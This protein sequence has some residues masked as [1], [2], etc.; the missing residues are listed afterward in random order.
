MENIL[1]VTIDSLRADHVGY[2]GYDRDTTPFIDSLAE[3]GSTFT[4]AYAHVGG[5]RFSF[6][7]ILSGVTP[8]MYGGYERISEDQ[9]LVSE[10]FQEAGYRTGGFHS[11]L[12]VSAEFG[13]DRGFEEFYDSKE[14]P[15]LTSQVRRFVRTNMQDSALYPILQKGYDFVE[16]S[17]GVNI[18]SYH[19]PADELTDM[20]LDFVGDTDPDRP[21]FLWVHYMDVHHPFIPPAEHQRAF[22]DSVV[23]DRE[24]IKLRRKALEGPDELTEDE[25]GTLVDLYDAEIR[26]ND[27]EV[28]RL[29]E[30]TREE[31]NDVT[32][33]LTADHGE[34]FLEHGY[35]SG[36][37]PYDVKLHVP[38]LVDGW[39]D[40]G[41]YDELVGLVDL[42]PTL[43]DV[44]GLDVPDS[45]QGT[46]LCRLVFDGEWNR[47][48]IMGG[49]EIP[50]PT[51]VYR[52]LR[53]KYIQRPG[54][55]SD[56]LYDLEADPDESENVIDQHPERVEQ[57][58]TKLAD[59]K[60]LIERTETDVEAVEIDENVKERLRRLGYQE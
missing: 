57:F 42:P 27:A 18:G 1:L 52:D 39:D 11:N 50:E 51:Y 32:V 59:H 14:D 3:T 49:W 7:S 43:L 34:H 13:Y 24:A 30:T 4:N 41:S 33:A 10:V 20:A 58:E 47:T 25:L 15:S 5:T 37:Q 8:L 38:L 16:S 44:A 29:V 36:A 28:R 53:W 60:L 46:S 31:W 19:V 17:Q 48:E 35:F 26:F 22:R 45:Y 54:N 40:A 21:A 2:H 6:P 9:T 55:E 56:E 23:D 12:Y